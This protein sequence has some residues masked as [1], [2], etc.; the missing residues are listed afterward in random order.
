MIGAGGKI[1]VGMPGMGSGIA[2]TKFC[3]ELKAILHA[4]THAGQKGFLRI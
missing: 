3:R 1:N 4:C 2:C